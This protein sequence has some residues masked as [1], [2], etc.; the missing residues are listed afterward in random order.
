M[1]DVTVLKVQGEAGV[2]AAYACDEVLLEGADGFLGMVGAVAIQ[3]DKLEFFVGFGHEFLKP[4]G[5]FIVE[6]VQGRLEAAQTEVFVK[7]GVAAHEFCFGTSFHG[8]VKYGVGVTLVEY[9]E[10]LVAFAGCGGETTGLVSGDF[11]A[12][13]HG[14]CED[15]IGSDAQLIG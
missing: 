4:G 15:P 9:H 1:G 11:S 2:V 8:L 10:L 5:A 14:F 13:F 6:D 7:G 3:R 12:Y